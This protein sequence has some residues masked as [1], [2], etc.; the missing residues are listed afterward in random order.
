VGLGGRF[1]T[2]NVVAKP[3]ATIITPISIDHPEFL[4]TTIEEIA[5]A[6]AGIFKP[7]APAIL[8]LQRAEA[9]AVL[10]REAE[11][12]GA[13]L[14][15]A[16]QDFLAREEHGRLIFEDTRGLI[17]LPLPR[18]PG[19]H[20]HENAATAIAA[21]RHIEP[22]LAAKTFER[23]LAQVEWPARLQNLTKGHVLAL[24][25]EGAEIWLDGGH[26]EDCGRVLGQ[27]MADF[28]EKMPRPLVL[29]CGTL[30]TKDTGAFLRAFKGLAQQVLAVPV[31]GDYGRPARDVAA[32]AD[33]AGLRAAACES[34]ESA[35]TFLAAHDWRVPPRILITGSLYLAGEVLAFN[36]TPPE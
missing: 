24:A 5:L 9:L 17:D 12:V 33:A 11:R 6:K 26:N 19:R 23:G 35:L 20:Q 2:T 32:A 30:A 10:E 18:L 25:P 3:K 1:D 14:I 34:V 22:D 29:I 28:E 7:G 4:G 21:L 36:G 8:G 31:S 27:A 15:I 16:G 13:P